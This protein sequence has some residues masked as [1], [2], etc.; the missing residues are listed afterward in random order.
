MRWKSKS[1]INF[2]EKRNAYTN[3]LSKIEEKFTWFPILCDN[4]WRWFEN[5]KIEMHV[6]KSGRFARGY[7]WYVS[8]F[9]N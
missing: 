2:K 6:R 5:V 3:N 8:K 7:K 1:G 4:E 9:I